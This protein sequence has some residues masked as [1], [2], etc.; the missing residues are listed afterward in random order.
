MEEV[1]EKGKE[2]IKVI[3]EQE[4]IEWEVRKF[5]YNLYSEGEAR[6]DKEEILK[7][8]DVLTKIDEEDAKRLDTK[9]ME[10]E[11]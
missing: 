2:T 3:S 5:Y 10:E 4:S 1:D 8:I 6:I 7:N 9:I 11:V